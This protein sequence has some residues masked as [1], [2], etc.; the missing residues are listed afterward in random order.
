LEVGWDLYIGGT[1]LEKYI[2]DEIKQMIKPGF[3]GNKIRRYAQ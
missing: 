3:I 1:K 2:D